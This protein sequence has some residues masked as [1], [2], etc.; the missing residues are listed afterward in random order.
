MSD[1]EYGME[2][3]DASTPPPQDDDE[4]ERPVVDPPASGVDS[5]WVPPPLPDSA[6][7]ASQLFPESVPPPPAPAPAIE[8]DPVAQPEVSPPPSADSLDVPPQ[9]APS[10]EPSLEMPASVPEPAPPSEAVFEDPPPSPQPVIEAPTAPA[11]SAEPVAVASQPVVE[12]PAAPSP[13]APEPMI[14][15]EAPAPPV[16]LPVESPAA[17]PPV[18]APAVVAPAVFAPP[19]LV[20]T[21]PI[22]PAVVAPA[23][24]TPAPAAPAAP[25]PVPPPPPGPVLPVGAPPVLQAQAEPAPV[26]ASVVPVLADD[27]AAA[28]VSPV[29]TLVDESHDG[30]EVPAIDP[31]AGPG[32]AGPDLIHVTDAVAGGRSIDADGAWASGRGGSGKGAA[33]TGGGRSRIMLAILLVLALVAASLAYLFLRP[34]SSGSAVAMSMGFAEGQRHTYKLNLAINGSIVASGQTVPIAEHVTETMT[35][36]VKKVG[37]NGVA[38]VDASVR[39]VTVSVNGKTVKVPAMSHLTFQVGQDGQMISGDAMALTSGSSS[40]GTSV[41]GLDQFT[42]LLPDHSVKPGDSWS[43]TFDQPNPFGTGS[44]HYTT[45]TSYVDNEPMQGVNAA[46]LHSSSTIPLD[47][48]IDLRKMLDAVGSSG[49][50]HLN[51]SNPK[52]T[53][54]GTVTLDQTSWFDASQ[55]RLLATQANGRF[56]LDLSVSG[57]PAGQSFPGGD[58]KFTGDATVGL[59]SVAS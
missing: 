5:A 49:A 23:I 17:P 6:S 37:S 30:T 12:P 14:A 43:K 55:N 21:P 58:I 50:S 11:P 52:F 19:P 56:D 59:T 46:V 29:T 51:G 22:A 9:A 13:A 40:S 26:P 28:P 45:Q 54:K 32:D 24:P 7:L 34:G 31:F 27:A 4:V 25:P 1:S 10:T 18:V 2:Q 44:I 8:P 38:T 41:P 39:H 53:Y 48:T 16:P 15:A 35:W 3:G 42:P 33:R 36:K 20:A 57:L 47:M